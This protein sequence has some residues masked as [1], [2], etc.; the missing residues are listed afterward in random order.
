[1]HSSYRVLLQ[2]LCGFGVYILVHKNL[3]YATHRG[4][5]EADKGKDKWVVFKGKNKTDLE[6]VCV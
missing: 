5:F 4:M 6:G 1:M 2:V 3:S